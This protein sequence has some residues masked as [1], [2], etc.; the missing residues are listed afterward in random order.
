ML[1]NVPTAGDLNRRIQIRVWSDVPNGAFGVDQ[2]FGT[3]ISRWAK[4]D[5]IHSLAMRAGVNTGEAVTD[6]FWV[7]WGTGT[8]PEDITVS[9]VIEL[10]GQ[11]YRVM[12][13]I[14]VSNLHRFTRISA[15]HLGAI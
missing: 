9:H 6:L 2:V 8:K 14:D 13:A 4:R 15:K 11:R 7:R 1:F 5:P 10:D 3:A 12:D